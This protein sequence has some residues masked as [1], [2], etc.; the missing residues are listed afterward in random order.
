MIL[1]DYSHNDLIFN[2]FQSREVIQHNEGSGSPDRNGT[3][4]RRC[5]DQIDLCRVL[6]LHSILSHKYTYGTDTHS[7]TMALLISYNRCGGPWSSFCLPDNG[8]QNQVAR[9]R[10]EM[11]E[12]TYR[13]LTSTAIQTKKNEESKEK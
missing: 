10:Q 4:K 9:T 13:R 6:Y 5:Y 1:S 2:A 7:Q 11:L 12:S 8:D 3:R